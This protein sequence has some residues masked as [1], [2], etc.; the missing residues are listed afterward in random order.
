MLLL[1]ASYFTMASG[2]LALVAAVAVVALQT[3]LGSRTGGREAWGL[4]SLA[5]VALATAALDF[6]AWTARRR[7]RRSRSGNLFEPF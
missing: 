6:R 3:A 1:T 2:A 7:S 5:A 4:A